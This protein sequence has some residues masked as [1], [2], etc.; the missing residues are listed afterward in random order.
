MRVKLSFIGILILNIA[1]PLFGQSTNPNST[2]MDF[3]QF[4]HS[5][6]SASLTTN[7]ARPLAQ[8]VIALRQEYGWLLDYEDPVYSNDDLMPLQNSDRLISHPTT[9]QYFRPSGGTFVTNY[10]EDLSSGMKT[11]AD[12][13]GVLAQ[14]LLDYSKSRNPGHFELLET[15]PSRLDVV[16]RNDSQIPVLD[17]RISIN[18]DSEPAYIALGDVLK[19]VQAQRGHR[20]GLGLAPITPLMHC[21]VTR[22]FT[23]EVAR[24]VLLDILELCQTKMVW[25][26]LYD[27]NH[28]SYLLNL[29]GVVISSRDVYGHRILAPAP[30]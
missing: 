30:R 9:K 29:D 21:S 2:H 23:N 14:V 28:D 20:I 3:G 17:T 13:K 18:I 5:D 22:V 7:D 19:L 25:Q 4:K 27:A 11:D 26:F 6:H 10:P 12:R 8:A 1:F 15:A 16:G 24:S